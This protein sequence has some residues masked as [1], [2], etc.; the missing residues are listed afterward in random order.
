[1]VTT[2]QSVFGT[3]NAT[4]PETQKVINRIAWY[5]TEKQVVQEFF[6]L[7]EEVVYAD[8]G[9]EIK[10]YISD[11]KNLKT[12]EEKQVRYIP[13]LAELGVSEEV[14]NNLFPNGLPTL[15]SNE[16]KDEWSTDKWGESKTS[17]GEE[18]PSNNRKPRKT[19]KK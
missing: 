14:F 15:K 13:R 1:M 17:W 5:R 10:D 9:I 12:L 3:V 19:K 2:M 18:K 4:N 7:R 16:K 8:D 6:G 11:F